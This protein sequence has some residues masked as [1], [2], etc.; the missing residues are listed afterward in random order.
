MTNEKERQKEREKI[1]ANALSK[2]NIRHECHSCGGIE[3]SL[4]EGSI[5][6]DFRKVHDGHLIIRI[7]LVLVICEN[8][9]CVRSY[10]ASKLGVHPQPEEKTDSEVI[11]TKDYDGRRT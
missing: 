10:E 11:K 8:C 4:S 5:I 9:G 6:T 7:F 1:I 3:F 2:K